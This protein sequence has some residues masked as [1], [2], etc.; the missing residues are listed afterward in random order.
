MPYYRAPSKPKLDRSQ[1]HTLPGGAECDP[2]RE[3]AGECSRL[4]KVGGVS[5]G[6]ATLRSDR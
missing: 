4:H 3:W 5:G 1:V 2:L 6:L